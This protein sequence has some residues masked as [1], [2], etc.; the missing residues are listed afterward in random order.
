MQS[1]VKF[2]GFSIS[3]EG[4]TPDPAMTEAIASFPAPQSLTNLR[5]FFGLVNQVAPFSEEIAELMEPLRPLLSSRR[6][7]DWDSCHEAAFAAARAAL[8]SV[9]T[10]AYFDQTR[11]TLLTTDAS[12]LK[13][14]GFLLQQKQTDGTWKVIQAGSRFLTDVESRY[15]TI[16]L[17]LLAVAWAVC[18]C[19]FSLV[20]LPHLDLVVDHRPLVPIINRKNMD[21]LENPRL[22]RLREKKNPKP[23]SPHP[24][25]RARNIRRPMRSVVPLWRD[26]QTVTSS[27]RTAR[28]L[29][30]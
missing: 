12:R 21:E 11:P 22:P 15:A 30:R 29:R 13:G 20:G 28:H 23:P 7:F 14:I 3:S 2:A 26:P 9:F 5:S 4:H 27:P 8:S 6:T 10:L 1:S 17:E 18:K 24:G 19:R 16:E 25:G